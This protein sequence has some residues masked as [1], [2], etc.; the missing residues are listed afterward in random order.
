LDFENIELIGIID[1]DTMLNFP[2][3]RSN[4]RSFQLFTQV[5]GRAGRRNH[6]G[7]VMIQTSQPKHPVLMF[8]LQNDYKG[9]VQWQLEERK[10]F[11]YPPFV[12]IVKID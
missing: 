4:E 1:A 8:L 11:N 5:S 12:R 7:L 9:F 2:D 3:F 10:K 6:Q